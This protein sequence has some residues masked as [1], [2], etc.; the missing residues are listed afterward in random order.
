MQGPSFGD[1]KVSTRDPGMYRDMPA[2]RNDLNLFRVFHF[3][4]LY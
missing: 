1:S 2:E 3:F 4:G